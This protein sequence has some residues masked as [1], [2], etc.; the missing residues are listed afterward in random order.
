MVAAGYVVETAL[1]AAVTVVGLTLFIYQI[2]GKRV[3][4]LSCPARVLLA[5]CSAFQHEL[6]TVCCLLC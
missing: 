4:S 3:V 5:G 1:F 2:G 6:I